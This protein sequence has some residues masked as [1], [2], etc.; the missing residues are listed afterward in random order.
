M[1]VDDEAIL[2]EQVAYYRARAPQYDRWWYRTH[3][4]ELDP[5]RKAEWD[6]EV[7]ELERT[8]AALVPA[9]P[10]LELAAGTGLGTEQLAKGATSITAVDS[11]PEAIELNR[12]RLA[13]A[14][15]PIE[16]VEADVF[17]WRPSRRY[18]LV[19]FSF[20]LSHVPPGRFATFWEMVGDA[21]AP[22]GQAVFVDNKWNDGTWRQGEDR[23]DRWVE[24]R[25]DIGDEYRIVKQ[26]WEP[27]ELTTELEGLGWQADV[28]AIGRAFVIGTAAPAGH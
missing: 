25:T 16:Y 13:D 24:T 14:T 12:A 8:I 1:S 4:Y 3:Q 21:L 15:I 28:W 18:D 11:S 9:G 5:E 7:A 27:I 20:W 23:P 17:T 19:F 10:V 6:A 2:A 22:G 26:Y